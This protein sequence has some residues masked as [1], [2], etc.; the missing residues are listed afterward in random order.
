MKKVELINPE[1]YFVE[2]RKAVQI[3]LEKERS[4]YN[5]M[6][7]QTKLN[8]LRQRKKETN[9][10]EEY[11]AIEVLEKQ[12]EKEIKFNHPIPLVPEE[13]KETIA[14]NLTVEQAEFNSKLAELKVE[15]KNQLPYLQ[16][17][18][19]PLLINIHE[20]GKLNVVPMN[21]D[22]ILDFE[23]LDGTGLRA[24]SRVFKISNNYK[25]Q[26]TIKVEKVI[27]AISK[28]SV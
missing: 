8:L 25:S 5:E 23:I 10:I 24:E 1:Q 11:E 26:S 17:V 7:K 27:M 9:S 2:S 21:I 20:L 14:R 3:A 28:M 16:N 13:Y 18:L 22:F 15:L 6:P 12:L 19:L 4:Y